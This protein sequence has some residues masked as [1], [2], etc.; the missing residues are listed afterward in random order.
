M[1]LKPF[2]LKEALAGKPVV[3]RNGTPIV[4]IA[5][6][7]DAAADSQVLA[8]AEGAP[9]AQRYYADGVFTRS[10]PTSEDLFIMPRKRE[11]WVN[12]YP[13]GGTDGWQLTE[14]TANAVSTSNRIACVRGEWLE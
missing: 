4:F 2:D 13:G 3:A 11:A 6:D 5:H 10:G 1:K 8:R 9:F 7:P 14:E 12:I